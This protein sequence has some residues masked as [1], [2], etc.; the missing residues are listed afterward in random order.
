MCVRVVVYTGWLRDLTASPQARS[1]AAGGR[2][3]K[4]TSNNALVDCESQTLER[5]SLLPAFPTSVCEA[6]TPAPYGPAKYLGLL[7]LSLFGLK[8]KDPSCT[9]ISVSK[10]LSAQE[11]VSVGKRNCKF[12][13]SNGKIIAH[14]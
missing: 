6:K 3:E 10:S 9:R 5:A 14:Q 7:Q 11:E 8:S 1:D 2:I 4:S 12:V 13:I